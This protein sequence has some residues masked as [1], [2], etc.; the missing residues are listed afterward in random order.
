MYNYKGKKLYEYFGTPALLVA[1]IGMV[2]V[3][4]LGN[5]VFANIYS[6]LLLGVMG[7][8]PSMLCLMFEPTVIYKFGHRNDKGN[9]QLTNE[10]EAAKK[11]LISNQK[12]SA[13]IIS[14]I[15]LSIAVT[16]HLL[17]RFVFHGIEYVNYY[18]SLIL[19]LSF[20]NAAH[21][22]TVTWWL[23]WS[24]YRNWDKIQIKYKPID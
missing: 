22:L 20:W 11:Y 21:L 24:T 17:Y 2:A 23:C 5:K 10:E 16:I 18:Y 6:T 15:Y 7:T 8:L 13:L 12:K 19:S 9:V 1:P 14:F 4:T 3:T